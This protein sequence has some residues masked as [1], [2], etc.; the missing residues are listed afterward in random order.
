GRA[1]LRL[2]ERA[3]LW[4]ARPET[5]QL[6]TWWEW[7]NIRLFTRKSHW[8]ESQWQMMRTAAR[9]H[10]VGSTLAAMFLVVV[11]FGALELVRHSDNQAAGLVD[12]LLDAEIGQ[13]PK[14]VTEMEGHR[15]WVNPKLLA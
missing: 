4:S 9:R 8:T 14:I 2:A 5:R 1:E 10:F 7:L 13:V 3:A 6:P 15:R 11:A 12:R